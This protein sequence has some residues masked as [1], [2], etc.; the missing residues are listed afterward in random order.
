M[1]NY[2]QIQT[3]T[4]CNPTTWPDVLQTY[5]E[6]LAHLGC[7]DRRV[8]EW[9]ADLFWPESDEDGFGDI[10]ADTVV[11]QPARQQ[12]LTCAGIEVSL[13]AEAGI[14][15][16]EDP[17]VWLGLN[18]L[19]DVDSLRARSTDPY[20][21]GVGGTL[22]SILYELAGNFDEVGAY[23]TD[24]WQENAAW[25]AIVESAGDPWAFELGIF[26]RALAPHFQEVP[27]GY[28]GTV[29]DGAFGF[30]QANRWQILPWDEEQQGQ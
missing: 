3:Y 24:P 18:L 17:P 1:S 30:A 7:S 26:P 11:L 29:L 5:W 15:T 23:F 13:Y 12:K 25:R 19:V 16:L 9:L 20:H 2:A 21:K 6:V 4:T 14:P 22:W 10:F 27:P 28:Q 8:E